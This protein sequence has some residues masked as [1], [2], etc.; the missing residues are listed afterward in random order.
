MIRSITDT[1]TIAALSAQ[2]VLL[3]AGIEAPRVVIELMPR[4]WSSFA[5]ERN[6]TEKGEA[7]VAGAVV[8]PKLEGMTIRWRP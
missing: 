7:I 3:E 8:R 4:D 1:L 6:I 5:S 2:N